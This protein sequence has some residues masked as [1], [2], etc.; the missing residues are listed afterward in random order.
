MAPEVMFIQNHSFA[1]DYY[2][3]GVIGYELMFGKRPYINVERKALKQEIF[4]KEVQ[5]SKRQLP[6]NFSIECM[7]FINGLIRRKQ[8]ERLGFEGI[9]KIFEHPW[10][11][12][13]DYKNIYLKKLKSPLNI[14]INQGGNFD[15]KNVQY[16]KYLHL[17]NKTKR[18]YQNII[19]HIKEYQHYFKDYYFYFNEFD[20]FDRKNTKIINKFI[21]P[22]KKYNNNE[23]NKDNL[24][25]EKED[26]INIKT[27][28]Y[29]NNDCSS[30]GTISNVEQHGDN[31]TKNRIHSN[32]KHKLIFEKDNS[33]DK[34]F[35]ELIKE[36][37]KDDDSRVLESNSKK[38]NII[39][40]N[41]FK[42]KIR[43]YMNI[44]ID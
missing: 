22:H 37:K 42:E 16:N 14:Y 32:K 27:N 33:I 19:I 13:V 10:L 29:T 43:K 7:N 2:A 39:N 1:V 30:T 18:R 41:K 9:N 34:E 15:L 21:N 17:T 25:W 3:L 4:A 20:L 44:K 35:K 31:V 36:I 12:D 24:Y 40:N 23:K 26:D 38:V 5:I 8:T 6:K 28:N 11:A